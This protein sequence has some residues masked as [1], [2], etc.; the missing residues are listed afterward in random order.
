MR[1]CPPH[2]SARKGPLR[3][4]LPSCDQGEQGMPSSS[5]R[6]VVVRATCVVV[7]PRSSP[8]HCA[9]F[10]CPRSRCHHALEEAVRPLAFFYSLSHMA[11]CT[12]WPGVDLAP[13]PQRREC[14]SCSRNECRR[15]ET[16][17]RVGV[18]AP[19]LIVSPH[20]SRALA[21]PAMRRSAAKCQSCWTIGCLVAV[22]V[23]LRNTRRTD[24]FAAEKTA[25]HIACI[26]LSS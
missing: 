17:R 5:I 23:H 20:Q 11:T 22:S 10:L 6:R 7:A 21:H 8:L 15:R 4:G 12:E 16:K 18:F 3:G 2:A 26:Y 24:T 9:G 25:A 1:P 14:R 13:H 19:M